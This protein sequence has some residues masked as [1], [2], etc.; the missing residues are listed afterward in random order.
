MSIS[1]A[2]GDAESD[3]GERRLTAL[4]ADIDR[5]ISSMAALH[6]QARVIPRMVAVLSRMHNKPLQPMSAAAE[7]AVK[8]AKQTGGSPES[9]TLE[10]EELQREVA[11]A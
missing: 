5:C 9:P 10:L 3:F 11:N 1:G 4:E 2:T 7:A 6:K 8:S